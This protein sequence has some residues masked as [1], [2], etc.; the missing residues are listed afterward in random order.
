[1]TRPTVSI[2]I[3][4]RNR[5]QALVR[6]LTAISQL[7]F[8]PF[9]VIVVADGVGLAAVRDWSG[10]QHLKTIAFDEAN[11]SVARN[12]GIAQAAGDVVAFIDDDAVPEPGWLGHLAAALEDSSVSAAGGYVRGRNGI[13][14][15]WTARSVDAL[16]RSEPLEVSG[17]DAVVLTPSPGRAIK[18]E[19]TNM[20]FRRS[21]LIALGGFDPRYRYFLD[22]TDLNMR[23]AAKGA[24]TAIVP[25]AVVHH[26]FAPNAIRRADRVPHD[27]TQI[28]ASWAVF[29]GR[30]C[31]A[32]AVDDR[33]QDI[34]TAERARLVRYMVDGLL[35]PRDVRRLMRTLRAGYAEGRGRAPEPNI[36]MPDDMAAFRAFPSDTNL[37][38]E[39]FVGRPWSRQSL[40]QQAAEAVKSGKIASVFIFS[41]T[42]LYHR[43]IFREDGIWE[44]S[45]GLFGKSLRSDPVFQ[46]WSFRKRLQREKTL[47]SIFQ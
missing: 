9:E 6:C 5:P 42:A 39:S 21:V 41:P 36:K 38:I 18:T 46:L 47:W 3:V 8:D 2:V 1:M 26:G 24:R 43:R 14:W 30:H 35:E 44:Q 10:N 17:D 45:G 7:R 29:L 34:Q 19:G 4:S 23:L 20:A 16:G 22:E 13:S 25:R 40:L 12:L 28:G 31:P 37:Q 27:L 32:D 15:Q 11:I 33:W